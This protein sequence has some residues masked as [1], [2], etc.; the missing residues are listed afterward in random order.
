MSLAWQVRTASSSEVFPPQWEVRRVGDLVTLINGFPFSSE[1]FGPSG[2]L[3]LVRIR[4]LGHQPFETYVSGRIPE[5][6]IVR[7]GDVVIG[8]DGDFNLKIWDR[9]RA[10]LNQRLC[11]LRPRPGVDIR[12]VAYALPASLK[13]INDLTFSTTV[14]HLSSGDVLRER[15]PLPPVEEQRRIADFLDAETSRIDRMITLRHKQLKLWAERTRSLTHQQVTSTTEE[16]LG[17][18]EIDWLGRIPEGWR[19]PTI[20]RIA[21]FIMG[22]TFPHE[23]QGQKSGHYPFIKVSD[24]QTADGTGRIES[25]ENWI[26]RETANRL[27]A[28]IVPP[29]CILYA[30][31]GAA[32]L[33]NRRRITVRPSVIDDN[34]RAINFS[35][36]DPRFWAA[37]LNLLDMGQLSN[38]GAVPSISESQ[39]S[40]VRIPDPDD[41]TQ[42]TIANRL[43]TTHR[44]QHAASSAI[45]RQLHLLAE[46]RQ[47]LITAA[48]TGQFDVS[49]AS[50]R[51]VTDGVPA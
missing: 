43:E 6:S 9:G 27:G 1:T 33:L 46:R 40:S 34:V 8:M 3:P 39:V 51:N 21:R 37:L 5:A 25:A 45:Q 44:Y 13:I 32:L 19:A 26:T 15:M 50:G 4:D 10:A 41:E 47:A 36:G 38:P 14:K 11:L 24:F 12:F 49:T 16:A 48:V 2:D 22:T 29:G 23:Y 20:G 31:V 42:T 18:L 35:H 7:N 30:R 28:R 17:G